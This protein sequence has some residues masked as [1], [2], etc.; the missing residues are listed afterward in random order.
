VIVEA[1]Y[2]AEAR[3]A[4]GA[5]ARE[6]RPERIGNESPSHRTGFDDEKLYWVQ[7]LDPAEAAALPSSSGPIRRAVPLLAH[8]KR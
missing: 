1:D 2:A 4:A 3:L 6:R 5:L 7:Q 8:N